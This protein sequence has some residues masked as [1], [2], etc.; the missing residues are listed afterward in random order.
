MQYCC[1]SIADS[2]LLAFNVRIM[3][4]SGR[5]RY[6]NLSSALTSCAAFLL[7]LVYFVG[8]IEFNSIH[9][10]F[11]SAHN[12]ELHS[13]QNEKEACH[14]AIYHKADKGCHHKT[15]LVSNDKC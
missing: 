13:E 4:F 2:V 14:Q 1:K 10:L 9:S 7:L 15:H 11:H 6:R 3:F 12:A 5:N 8:S